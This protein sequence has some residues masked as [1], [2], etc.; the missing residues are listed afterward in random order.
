MK[1]G[2][3]RIETAL[4]RL[5]SAS[6]IRRGV[7]NRIF[8]GRDLFADKKTAGC[9]L[10]LGCGPNTHPQ[11]CNLDYEW[12]PGVDVVWNVTRGL[13]FAD[14]YFG[15]VYSEHMLE[16][17]P[18]A[19]ALELLA[20]CR[21]VLRKGSVLRI[22]V[23]DGQFYLSE[24]VK[25]L[26]GEAICLPHGDIDR[27]KFSIVTPMVSVNRVF[28]SHGHKFIWDFETLSLALE[29]AGFTEVRKCAFHQGCDPKLLLDT[30]YRRSESL[31]VEA[32]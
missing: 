14:G 23:P 21:R 27:A 24:Y 29:G 20:E 26:A 9:Y 13:P 16:H 1:L 5:V 7:V 3:T 22:A 17:L 6:K 11:F 8:R 2:L 30:E 25:H 10:N 12:F 15:G 18:F 32:G 19:A 31:Y 4:W 28:Y